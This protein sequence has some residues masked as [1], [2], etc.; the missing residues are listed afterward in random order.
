MQGTQVRSLGG[1]DTL[2]EGMATHSSILAWR[3]PWTEEPAGLP[4]ISLHRVKHDWSNLAHS[5]GN[6]TPLPDSQEGS[7]WQ[8]KNWIPHKN[9]PGVLQQASV[10]AETQTQTP[11]QVLSPEICCS[12][13]KVAG[14]LSCYQEEHNPN[15]VN[16][17]WGDRWHA[18]QSLWEM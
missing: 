13:Q 11:S 15:Q 3:I 4:S 16:R 9:L 12:F 10:Q 18:E 7:P 2:E 8:W 17:T 5:T 6:R 1:E 14:R